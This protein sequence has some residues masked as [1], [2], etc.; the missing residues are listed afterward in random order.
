MKG[1]GREGYCSIRRVEE[2][3][4]HG[5]DQGGGL[6]LGP[7]E[8]SEGLQP[9]IN[10]E[11]ICMRHCWQ[12]KIGMASTFEHAQ[13]GP[14]DRDQGNGWMYRFGSVLS[15]QG[16]LILARRISVSNSSKAVHR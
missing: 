11:K 5:T 12:D 2:W 6:G 7:G 14:E 13:T 8:E 15:P 9:R 3:R 10:K 1:D 4:V 16:C